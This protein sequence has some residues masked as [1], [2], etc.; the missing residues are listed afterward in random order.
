MEVK[1]YLAINRDLRF[2][3]FECHALVYRMRV[4]MGPFEPPFE[5]RLGRRKQKLE[6]KTLP[7]FGAKKMRLCRRQNNAGG[8]QAR[9][10]W[11]LQPLLVENRERICV[12]DEGEA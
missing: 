9:G 1:C 6:D 3:L 5:D 7:P 4:Q 2:D 8:V 12:A 11:C 10:T